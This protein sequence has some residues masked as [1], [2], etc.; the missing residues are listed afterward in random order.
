VNELSL[1]YICLS[2][3]LR[4]AMVSISKGYSWIYLNGTSCSG[5]GGDNVVSITF[6]LSLCEDIFMP[7]VKGFLR[8]E[9]CDC[10]DSSSVIKLLLFRFKYFI[11]LSYPIELSL[12]S[13][14]VKL[15]ASRWQSEVRDYLWFFE[16]IKER[17]QSSV[18]RSSLSFLNVCKEAENAFSLRFLPGD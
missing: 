15:S 14:G 3:R 16:R 13:S 6:S 5:G 11:E 7:G 9:H 17:L 4:I 10:Y 1:N 18:L 8:V 2:L 12:L